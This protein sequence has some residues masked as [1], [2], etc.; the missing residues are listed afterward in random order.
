MIVVKIE[1]LAAGDQEI[2]EGYVE[3][4]KYNKDT[5]KRDQIGERQV[6]PCPQLF[7]SYSV[8]NPCSATIPTPIQPSYA[9]H[10]LQ[11]E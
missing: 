4:H 2:E 1:Y 7:S 8:A 11:L 6:I 10:Q 3:L 9:M 5:E